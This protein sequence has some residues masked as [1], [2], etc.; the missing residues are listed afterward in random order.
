MVRCSSML[1]NSVNLFDVYGALYPRTM[2]LIDGR[3]S[4]ING[5]M[6]LPLSRNRP[7]TPLFAFIPGYPHKP[8]KEQTDVGLL[9]GDEMSSTEQHSSLKS[10]FT[11]ANNQR[12]KLDSIP[13]SSSSVYQ[14]NLRAAIAAFHECRQLTERLSVFSAN[15]TEDDIS[16]SDLQYVLVM[17]SPSYPLTDGQ[18]GFF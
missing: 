18:L 15:E 2:A 5:K 8:L 4:V 14:D 10:L 13:D 16:S 1:R 7:A 6:D 3:L 11:N 12:H 17:C 9:I